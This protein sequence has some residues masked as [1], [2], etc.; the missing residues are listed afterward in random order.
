M[1]LDP[2][3]AYK[4][5]TTDQYRD[6]YDRIKWNNKETSESIKVQD[7]QSNDGEN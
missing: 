2:L 1:T 3:K 7:K 6:N 4:Q 5:P